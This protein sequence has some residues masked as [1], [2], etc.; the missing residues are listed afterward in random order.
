MSTLRAAGESYQSIAGILD[1]EGRKPRTTERWN[2][3]VINK[4]LRNAAAVQRAAVSAA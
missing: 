2:P 1:A 4:I 3:I